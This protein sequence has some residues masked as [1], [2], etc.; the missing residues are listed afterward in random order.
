MNRKTR[1]QTSSRVIV[2]A[3]LVLI[4]IL[5]LPRAT[6]SQQSPPPAPAPTDQSTEDAVRSGV[7]IRKESKLV[8]VDAVVT[9]KKGNYVRNLTQADFKVYEDNKEQIRE[10]Q[11]RS[12]PDAD[13]ARLRA[14][15]SLFRL[16][17][18]LRAGGQA[19]G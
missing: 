4:G 13:G 3:C 9:D 2:G 11:A 19:S 15:H 16:A 7:V 12:A 18:H 14:S 17:R 10:P 6:R 1:N 8:L 5:A